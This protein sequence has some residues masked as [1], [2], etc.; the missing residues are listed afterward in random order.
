M[1]GLGRTVLAR[2]RMSRLW[3]LGDR[4]NPSSK[5]PGLVLSTGEDMDVIWAPFSTSSD[6]S[7]PRTIELHS[8]AAFAPW[9][10]HDNG[11][12]MSATIGH[13]LPP[14]LDEADAGEVASKG[15]LL[16]VSWQS[17]NHDGELMESSLNPHV[18]VLTDALQL[19]N[20]PG[21]LVEA[22]HVIKRR[23]PGALLWAPGIGGPDN[24]AVMTWFG[25]DLFDT[26]R[27]QQAEAHGA[28]LTWNGPR[29]LSEEE[30]SVNHWEVALTETRSAIASNSLRELAQSQSLSS[31]RLVEHMRNYDKLMSNNIGHLSQI[32]D[33]NTSLR[34]HSIESHDDPIITDWVDFI[35]NEYQSPSSLD[36]VLVLLPCSARKPY[37]SSRS[38]QAFRRAMNHNSAHEVMVTSPLGLV[39]RDLE[40]VWP[41]GHYD[42]PVTGDWTQDE[43]T[44]VTKM[45]DAIVGRN[46]YR[47]IINHSGLKYQCSIP[48]IDTRQ[49][50]SAT[51]QT[52][53]KRLA[54]AVLDNMRVKRR[55][56]E[57][58]NLDSFRSVAR[59]HYNNDSWLDGVQVRGRFPRWKILKDEIQI[60][61]WAPE[62]GGF[63][64]SK[65]SIPLLDSLDSL[66]RVELKPEIKW[67]GD[68]NLA[69]LESYDNSIRKGEDIL[70]MQG[71]QCLG[72]A[73]AAAP[74]WE[75]EG[76]PGRLAKSHQR[77]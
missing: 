29:Y 71:S 31:P 16:P 58:M 75:W 41:A 12:T 9:E 27:S 26:T 11:P 42:I 49:G 70:V 10:S 4:A 5:T 47:V 2:H 74:A 63:S 15:D 55:S 48:V 39:P 6:G 69:I 38:H 57:M 46:K 37:S 67:K 73:R 66:K 24:C 53:L 44:R 50:D 52:A 33:S 45:L 34:I 56:G 60:A 17:L 36:D 40:E 28:V 54:E 7:I 30:P 23:F 65:S 21:R 19:A 3:G 25:I 18:V 77:V 51:S 13:V 32:V 22:I 61:M 76:T 59:F 72:S 62:R 1:A 8:R 68:I 35:T 14:S 64:L 43:V 20:R